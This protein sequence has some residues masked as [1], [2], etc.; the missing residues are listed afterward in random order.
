M[1]RFGVLTTCALLVSVPALAADDWT[2][3][4]L[5]N[6]VKVRELIRYVKSGQ[7]ISMAVGFW[8]ADCVLDPTSVP[9]IT[10]QPDHGTAT[11]EMQMHYPNFSAVCQMQR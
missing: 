2:Q 8:N 11:V 4:E 5:D 1:K 6:G 7:S 9:T 10:S 3:D